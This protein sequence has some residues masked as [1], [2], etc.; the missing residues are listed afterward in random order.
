[1]VDLSVDRLGDFERVPPY[2]M[3]YRR[4]LSRRKSAMPY[5]E[6]SV[7]ANTHVVEEELIVARHFVCLAQGKKKKDKVDKIESDKFVLGAI[8]HMSSIYK[9]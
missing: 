7:E 8:G 4:E 9:S 5:L 6:I 2:V 1:M 3:G